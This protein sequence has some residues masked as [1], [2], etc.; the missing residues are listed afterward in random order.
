M[1]QTNQQQIDKSK[2]PTNPLPNQVPQ[3][4]HYQPQ[5]SQNLP[6]SYSQT[7]PGLGYS[8]ISSQQLPNEN[9]NYVYQ[10]TAHQQNIPMPINDQQFQNQQPFQPQQQYF[11]Q[12]NQSGQPNISAQNGFF[13]HNLQQQQQLQQNPQQLQGAFQPQLPQQFGQN[14][15]PPHPLQHQ[16]F[17][18]TTNEISENIDDKVQQL[19]SQDQLTENQQLELKLN[20]SNTK[21][22]PLF[23]NDPYGDFEFKIN[24]KIYVLQKHLLS[25]YSEYFKGLCNPKF[26]LSSI[27]INRDFNN[28]H[29]HNILS[30]FYGQVIQVKREQIPSYQC[31][32]DFIKLK[33]LI[34]KICQGDQLSQQLTQ[35]L[36]VNDQISQQQTEELQNKKKK[37]QLKQQLELESKAKQIREQKKQQEIE[38]QKL[39][40]QKQKELQKQEQQKKKQQQ[41]LEEQKLD[42]QKQ[43]EQQK[44]KQ[45]QQLE[46]QRKQLDEQ[47]KQKEKEQEK[48]K[49]QQKLD[50][51]KK[52]KNEKKQQQLNK[53]TQQKQAYFLKQQNQNQNSNHFSGNSD[54]LR[55]NQP[56]QQRNSNR[57][58]QQQTQ[59]RP[60][61]ANQFISNQNDYP[62]WEE[63]QAEIEK[64]QQKIQENDNNLLLKNDWPALIKLEENQ[65]I[66]I[67]KII[68][69]DLKCDLSKTKPVFNINANTK[70]ENFSTLQKAM[71]KKA[72]YI[73]LIQNLCAD[74][75]NNKL[76]GFVTKKSPNSK[77]T[78]DDSMFLFS[79]DLKTNEFKKFTQKNS[80]PFQ[81]GALNQD[82]EEE[83][84]QQQNQQQQT[85][86]N[87]QE[88]QQE[89]LQENSQ[90][91]NP[92][93]YTYR[94]SENYIII[95]SRQEI[96]IP[97]NPYQNQTY[98]SL[99]GL[100]ACK[101]FPRNNN[102][103]QIEALTGEQYF[104]IDNF[105]VLKC[106]A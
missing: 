59:S 39:N 43:K 23:P 67:E 62:L 5:L 64:E 1:R 18:Q 11:Y 40:L 94:I 16:Q 28:E 46:E 50:E 78:H 49:N 58:Q 70:S 106:S 10:N 68:T 60:R 79:F 34:I 22:I 2:T 76:F 72:S 12:Q 101:D 74:Q 15:I 25:F 44:K 9:Q 105:L 80:K 88:N 14:F 42:L 47:R 30:L 41:K 98:C 51:F 91:N 87:L 71:R 56:I 33:N 66:Q 85:E 31:I 81:N 7:P 37:Q 99:S 57:Q 92:N 104:F 29:I 63:D 3:S 4:M 83:E 82:G 26:C 100:F 95:G 6:N 45:Q 32:I 86:E 38:E 27:G 96:I 61:Q 19:P 48:I 53:E 75:N 17:V 65:K 77:F 52:K 97:E 93:N 35:Q 54:T 73:F 24:G 21:L 36:Q 55:Q 90:K 102:E 20:K 69:D 13:Q 84:K 103:K 8:N 89:N